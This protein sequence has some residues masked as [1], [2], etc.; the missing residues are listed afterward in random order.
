MWSPFEGSSAH[1]CDQHIYCSW[2]VSVIIEPR[3]PALLS[4]NATQSSRWDPITAPPPLEELVDQELHEGGD[5][6]DVTVSHDVVLR[7]YPAAPPLTIPPI[8]TVAS[9]VPPA[10]APPIAPTVAPPIPPEALAI[11]F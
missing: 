6:H 5:E 3:M 10:G 1:V 2:A 9:L 11:P 8:A 7:V 4:D